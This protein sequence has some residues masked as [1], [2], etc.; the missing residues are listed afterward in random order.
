MIMSLYRDCS[1]AIMKF[2]FVSLKLDGDLLSLK[3]NKHL[4]KY[5]LYHCLCL[6]IL[7]VCYKRVKI[8]P[9]I[10]VAAHDQKIYWQTKKLASSK[11]N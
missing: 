7:S 8:S 6:V 11:N 9:Y 2:D 3:L 4:S 1:G 5:V 10:A